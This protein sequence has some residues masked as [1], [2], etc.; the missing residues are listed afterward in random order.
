MNF[1]ILPL[2]FMSGALYPL[3]RL[4]HWLSI[5]S[6]L[7]PMTYGIDLLRNALTGIHY[8]SVSADVLALSSFLMA[9]SFLSI[10]LFNKAD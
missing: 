2:F 8:Y 5:A 7:D 10:Y 6:R 3:D 9:M 1:I 4:P